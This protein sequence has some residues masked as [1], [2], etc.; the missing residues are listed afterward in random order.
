MARGN[1]TGLAI[2]EPLVNH[3]RRQ[4]GEHFASPGEIKAAML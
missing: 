2:F 3:G 4:P 1:E